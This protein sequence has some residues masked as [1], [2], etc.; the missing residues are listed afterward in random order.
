MFP[1]DT[2]FGEASQRIGLVR[3]PTVEEGRAVG[4]FILSAVRFG[5]RMFGLNDFSG[6]SGG[7]VRIRRIAMHQ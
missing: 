4:T 1:R 7:R 5:T 6:C 2:V 3:K